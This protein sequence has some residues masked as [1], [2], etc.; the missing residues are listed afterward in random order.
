MTPKENPTSTKAYK[1]DDVETETNS[2]IG[3]NTKTN[4]ISDHKTVDL[5]DSD[6]GKI[7]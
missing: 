4:I 6:D 7:E 3:E 2:D 5:E 1:E